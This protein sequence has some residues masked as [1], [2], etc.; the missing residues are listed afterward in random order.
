M[1]KFHCWYGWAGDRNTIQ[2]FA[3]GDGSRHLSENLSGVR[4][5]MDVVTSVRPGFI[6]TVIAK[7]GLRIR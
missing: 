5:V 7:R 6:V 4:A 3:D 1:W 2:G